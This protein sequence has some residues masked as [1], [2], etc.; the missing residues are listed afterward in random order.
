MFVG[1]N[2]IYTDFFIFFGLKIRFLMP[3]VDKK[4]QK[5]TRSLPNFKGRASACILD[6][7]ALPFEHIFAVL[8]GFIIFRAATKPF[9]KSLV[10][11]QGVY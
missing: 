4:R 3:K 7:L 1:M 2:R 6:F 11:E 8:L 10:I 9:S 5:K